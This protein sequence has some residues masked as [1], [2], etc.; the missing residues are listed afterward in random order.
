MCAK[1]RT[2]SP[3]VGAR[4]PKSFTE[5]TN[6]ISEILRMGSME[7]PDQKSYRG[8]GAPGRLIEDLLGISENNNDSPD[9]RDWEVKFHGGTALLTLFH[10]EPE[11]RGILYNL[12]SKHGWPDGQDRI[13]F[14]HTIGGESL[15]GFYVVNDTDRILVRHR[16]IDDVVPYWTHDTLLSIV[17]AKLRRL[18]VVEGSVVKHPVRTVH[19]N[20]ATAYWDFQ[21]RDFCNACASGQI[22]IDFDARTQQGRGTTLRNHGTK[23]RISINSLKDLYHNSKKIT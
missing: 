8:T 20:S 22:F 2:R 11:P 5:A 3:L 7:I 4:T 1:V 23:F 19:F 6:K 17:A 14:R 16:T 9:L 13:S 21:L 15:R 12:V 10:K 18:I